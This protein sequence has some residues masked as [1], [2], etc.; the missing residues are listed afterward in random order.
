MS[1]IIQTDTG[2]F[3]ELDVR[4]ITAEEAASSD[5]PTVDQSPADGSTE[6]ENASRRRL[7]RLLA[8]GGLAVGAAVAARMLRR[9]RRRGGRD[10]PVEFGTDE[11]GV[12]N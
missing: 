9:G 1:V 10:D 2:R 12:E 11:A 8:V 7:P 6:T 5:A 4:T 3:V